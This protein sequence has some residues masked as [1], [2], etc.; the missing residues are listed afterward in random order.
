MRERVIKARSKGKEDVTAVT[1]Y[2]A[3]EYAD[4]QE[5]MHK[6]MPST[7]AVLGHVQWQLLAFS[8]TLSGRHAHSRLP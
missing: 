7:R 5:V 4:W 1:V 8:Q 3:K 6:H 2:V